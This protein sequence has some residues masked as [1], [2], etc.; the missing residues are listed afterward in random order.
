LTGRKRILDKPSPYCS[1]DAQ[2]EV[3]KMSVFMLVE[4]RTIDLEK[5][6]QYI[7]QVSRLVV[8]Y[9]GRYLVRGGKITP[10]GNDWNPERIIILEFPSEER[11]REW[12][13]SPE[14]KAIAPLREAGAETR[15]V[16]LEGLN[17]V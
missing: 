17:G 15:A 11:V 8:Q 1:R 6:T 12:L 9:G 5:Y 13:S 3:G 14:Y 10:L 2:Y 4:A 7:S 16:L